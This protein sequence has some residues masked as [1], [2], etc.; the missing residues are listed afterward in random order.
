[1]RG[2]SLLN[3][4]F[5]LNKLLKILLKFSKKEDEKYEDFKIKRVIKNLCIEVDEDHVN[6]ILASRM[7]LERITQLKIA[8]GEDLIATL[9]KINKKLLLLK[10]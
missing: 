4:I 1:M 5:F 10:R 7:R 8:T 3:I 9:K 2:I 6:Y